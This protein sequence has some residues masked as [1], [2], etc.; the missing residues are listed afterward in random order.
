MVTLSILGWLSAVAVSPAR[1]A[2]VIADLENALMCKCDDECGK[3][4]INCTCDTSHKTRE[5]FRRH[6][7]S[8][9]SVE[10][11][12]QIYVDKYG[13]T[14]LSAPTK[15]GFNL[16]AWIMP[17]AAIL[18]GGWSIRRIARTW[19]KKKSPAS[20]SPAGKND[21][22]NSA[23][24]SSSKYSQQLQDELDKIEL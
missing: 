14:I 24:A 3:V 7:Q 2:V 15:S 23:P 10:Q 9:L 1:A 12:I 13:E 6:L 17:F 4:M 21:P 5:D 22:G 16:T 19:V 8:G 11:V 18:G 20:P